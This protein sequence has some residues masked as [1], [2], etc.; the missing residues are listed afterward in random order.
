MLNSSVFIAFLIWLGNIF[1]NSFLY[2][3]FAKFATLCKKSTIGKVVSLGGCHLKRENSVFYKIFSRFTDV[4]DCFFKK[5]CFIAKGSFILKTIKM[6]TY[7]IAPQPILI[8]I[9]SLR[10]K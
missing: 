10:V 1:E 7:G 9:R 3:L 4:I 2:R 8:M 5:L 6:V